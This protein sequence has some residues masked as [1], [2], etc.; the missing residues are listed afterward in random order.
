V[1]HFYWNASS[2][3]EAK[4]LAEAL[5]GLAQHQDLVV[6]RIISRVN[7]GDSISIKDE[8]HSEVS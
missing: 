8:R 6:L 7:E 1:A 2:S 3:T 5:R 4:N